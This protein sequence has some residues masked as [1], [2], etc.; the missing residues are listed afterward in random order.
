[1]IDFISKWVDSLDYFIGKPIWAA[2]IMFVAMP[3]IGVH[4]A[5]GEFYWGLLLLLV[6][7]PWFLSK[8][9][10]AMD[11]HNAC[12]EQKKRFDEFRKNAD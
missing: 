5:K 10:P 1:M 12:L 6:Q 11:S 7:V 3:G 2:F 8:V 9:A 4:F